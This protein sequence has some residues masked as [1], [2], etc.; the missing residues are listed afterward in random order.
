MR[1]SERDIEVRHLRAFVAVAQHG[2]VTRAAEQLHIAQPPLSRQI[3]QL[4]KILGLQLFI[5]AGSGVSLTT[6][7]EKLLNRARIVLAEVSYL[8]AVARSEQDGSPVRLGVTTGLVDALA[9]IR[10]YLQVNDPALAFAPV[11]MT[12]KLQLEALLRREIDVGFLRGLGIDAPRLRAR[13]LLRER[14]V[15]LM[16][17]DNPLSRRTT[18]RVRDIADEPLL[19]HH[20]HLNVVGYDMIMNVFEAAGVS[21]RVV[22]CDELPVLQAG[23]M[24]V[25]T[26]EAVAIGLRG[27][28]SHLYVPSND[29]VAITLD[30]PNA[31]YDLQMV[32]RADEDGAAVQRF[33]AAM[34]TLFPPP[35][36]PA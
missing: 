16:R 14:F 3:Q 7:G 12:P 28:W 2:S 15:V 13:S 8:N 25:V 21:P 11:D 4:E 17:K 10:S 1:H 36:A 22:S 27:D 18:L 23:M 33:I 29:V 20:R 24:R 30:E 6:A 19:L 31:F 35:G 9:R 5:R 32:W 34:T 26:G